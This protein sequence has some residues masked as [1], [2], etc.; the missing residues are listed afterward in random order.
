MG[1]TA[2][3]QRVCVVYEDELRRAHHGKGTSPVVAPPPV[4][5]DA[6]PAPKCLLSASPLQ[7]SAPP[8][9]PTPPELTAT[10]RDAAPPGT[11]EER[12]LF[13]ASMQSSGGDGGC[14][15]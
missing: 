15:W 2:L 5:T 6:E 8:L 4:A 1:H 10:A 9:P 3:Y 11:P 14:G 12:R 7:P 13:R